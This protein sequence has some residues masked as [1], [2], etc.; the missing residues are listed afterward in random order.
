ME[1]CV[2]ICVCTHVFKKGRG[3]TSFTDIMIKVENSKV[4][5]K[6]VVEVLEPGWLQVKHLP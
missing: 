5:T 4:S 2:C 3:K 1:L 6:K